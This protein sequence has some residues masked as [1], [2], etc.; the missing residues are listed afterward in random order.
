MSQQN[1]IKI[2]SFF[3]SFSSSSFHTLCK[4]HYNS[5]VL[6]SILLKFDTCMGGLKVNTSIDFWVNIL[7]IEGVI[8]DFTH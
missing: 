3:S 6:T 1:F 2:S 8:S 7:N 4:N 5:C